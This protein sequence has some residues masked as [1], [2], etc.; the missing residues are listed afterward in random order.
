MKILIDL[1]YKGYVLNTH[2]VDVKGL[3]HKTLQIPI[4]LTVTIDN[5]IAMAFDTDQKE[6]PIR[7]ELDSHENRA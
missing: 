7:K 2:Y 4:D 6:S 1:I 3:K 5:E